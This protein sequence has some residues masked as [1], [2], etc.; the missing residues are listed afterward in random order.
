MKALYW[1]A[2]LNGVV[3]VPMLSMMMLVASHAGVMGEF[4]VGRRLRIV[5]WIATSIIALSV[6]GMAI[7]ALL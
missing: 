1:S 6:I 3:A 4:T 7:A 5:G 2:I